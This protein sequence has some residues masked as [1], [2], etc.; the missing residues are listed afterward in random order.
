MRVFRVRFLNI[1]KFDLEWLSINFGMAIGAG[2]LMVP[3]SIGLIGVPL[4]IVA[5]LITYP[6]IY[7]LQR[8]Y[9]KTLFASKEPKV[10]S[11][12]IK[13]I[14]GKNWQVILAII[15]FMMMLIWTTIYAEVIAQ[16]FSDYAFSFHLTDNP[17]IKSNILVSFIFVAVLILIGFKSQRFLVQS[18]TIFAIILV[19][20]ILGITI[21][22]VPYWNVSNLAYVPESHLIIPKLIILIPFTLTS[23]FFIQTLSPMAMAYKEKYPTDIAEKKTVNGMK[24]AFVILT[25][26]VISFILSFSMT[27]SHDMAVSA[28]ENNYSGL[29][30]LNKNNVSNPLL[31]IFGGAINIFAI[32]TSFLS[33]LYG[34]KNSLVGILLI[35]MKKLNRNYNERTLSI[36]SVVSIFLITWSA[37]VFEYPMYVLLPLSGPIFAILGCFIPAYIVYKKPSLHHLKGWSLNFVIFIGIILL[38]SPLLTS[39]LG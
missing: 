25:I 23:I 24:I 16:T 2:I 31:N 36:I 19:V 21:S 37:I 33:I 28:V 9:I 20:A 17:D 32:L 39:F 30:L 13:D 35:I 27:I 38:I 18:I 1:D 22:L 11:E 4:F 6:G 14:L 3:I 7:L 34:M 26:M 29:T 10:Y 15:Y 12:T 5:V 8:I